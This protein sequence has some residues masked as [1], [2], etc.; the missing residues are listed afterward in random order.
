ME[1]SEIFNK[2]LLNL[3]AE[4]LFLNFFLNGITLNKVKTQHL[5]ILIGC[6]FKKFWSLIKKNESKMIY[7]MLSFNIIAFFIN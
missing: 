4:T 3:K 1:K 6:L 5:N 7:K 2:L